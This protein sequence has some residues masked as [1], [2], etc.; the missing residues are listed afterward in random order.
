MAMLNNQMVKLSP[1]RK[2]PGNAMLLAEQDEKT[3][4]PQQ[5]ARQVTKS[6]W[7]GDVFA[8]W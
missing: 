8:V 6:P 3:D 1:S 5:L 7:L 4:D 2:H